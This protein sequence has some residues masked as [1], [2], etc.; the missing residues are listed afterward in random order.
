MSSE[1][2]NTRIWICTCVHKLVCLFVCLFPRYVRAR[3]C[4]C[5]EGEVVVCCA[6]GHEGTIPS[7]WGNILQLFQNGRHRRINGCLHNRVNTQG[8]HSKVY[9]IKDAHNSRFPTF[10]PPPRITQL[11]VHRPRCA[12]TPSLK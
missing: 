3:V 12:F 5:Q 9:N 11:R 6:E 10:S 2:I 7:L 4:G 8:F 1:I